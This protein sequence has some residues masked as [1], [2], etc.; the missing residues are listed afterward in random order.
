MSSCVQMSFQQVLPTKFCNNCKYYH[1]PSEKCIFVIKCN[2]VVFP[3]FQI[4]DNKSGEYS[5]I[6]DVF[7]QNTLPRDKIEP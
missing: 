5:G 7:L 2:L 3:F 4:R 6:S 1:E